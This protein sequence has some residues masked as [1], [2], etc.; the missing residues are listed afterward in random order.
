VATVASIEALIRECSMHEEHLRVQ[1]T[2]ADRDAES[3]T[4]LL[5]LIGRIRQLKA[6]LVAM[7]PAAGIK[8]RFERDDA[9]N[10]RD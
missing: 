3:A 9:K 4:T 8:D 6:R 2:D 7:H 1:L 10:G 5:D